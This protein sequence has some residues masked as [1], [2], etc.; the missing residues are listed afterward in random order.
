MNW[1]STFTIKPH[2]D[3]T[4]II[5]FINLNQTSSLLKIHCCANMKANSK[6][7]VAKVEQRLHKTCDQMTLLHCT[8]NNMK[9]RHRRAALRG[10]SAMLH[11][12]ELRIQV[13]QSV[14]NTFY[15]CA[16]QQAQ[17]LML[18]SLNEQSESEA[19]SRD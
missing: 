5:L 17:Q 14:Y 9:L 4:S 19:S 7:T 13:V 2:I 8:I 12:L 16:A 6:I 10:H 3:Q 11:S 1:L 15:M 18:C